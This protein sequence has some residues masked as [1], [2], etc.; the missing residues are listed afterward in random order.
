MDYQFG[1][2]KYMVNENLNNYNIFIIIKNTS[3]KN[4][5]SNF[6]NTEKVAK[7]GYSGGFAG[8]IIGGQIW[9]QVGSMTE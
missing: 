2:N 1:K 9:G 8:H 6:A 7:K 4:V 3:I 5:I